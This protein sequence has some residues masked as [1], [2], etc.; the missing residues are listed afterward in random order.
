[1]VNILTH[2]KAIRGGGEMLPVANNIATRLITYF[3][4]MPQGLLKMMS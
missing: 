1:M 3:A 4:L 2:N